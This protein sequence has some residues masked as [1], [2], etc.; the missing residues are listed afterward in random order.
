MER[1]LVTGATGLVGTALCDRAAG[2]GATLY[3]ASLRGGG[4]SYPADLGTRGE[5]SSLLD[6][7]QPDRVFHLGAVASPAE[8]AMNVEAARRVNVLGST[9]IVQWCARN[10]R[11]LLFASTDQVFDGESGPY[12]EGDLAKPVTEYGRM[13][14]EVERL[15]VD[16][17]GLVARLGWVLNDTARGRPD[18]VQKSLA[19]LLAGHSIEAVID[20]KR[21]PVRL[22]EV[23]EIICGLAAGN[24]SGLIH[25][26]GP[27]HVTPY[28]L[29]LSE[30]M[31]AGLPTERVQPGTRA[32]LAPRGRP[33]DLRLNTARLHALK[34]EVRK[35]ALARAS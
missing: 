14:A 16:S 20:E 11:W 35:G 32:N 2:A 33:R 34:C 12:S 10:R 5:I 23:V 30:A 4:G 3:K 13:K 7:L 27:D 18:F 24:Q 31:R 1:W 26:A 28:E 15:V 21:T 19:H 22:S 25:V 6:A 17:G 9:E 29:I 8:V